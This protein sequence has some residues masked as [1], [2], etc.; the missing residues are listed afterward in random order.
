MYCRST[1]SILSQLMA[2]AW[3]T[4]APAVS[5]VIEPFVNVVAGSAGSREQS[6]PA[7][8]PTGD[9]AGAPAAG[10]AGP[11]VLR[12]HAAVVP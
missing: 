7:G 4:A 3:H 10:A 6:P 9:A 12:Q 5:L 2:R 8:R 11:G 1:A